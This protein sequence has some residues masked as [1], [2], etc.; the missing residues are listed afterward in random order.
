MKTSEKLKPLEK[1]AL[2]AVALRWGLGGFALTAATLAGIQLQAQ[3][4]AAHNSR[5]PVN[6][7]AGRIELQDRQNRVSLSGNVIV[8]QAGLT[9]NSQ[10]ML[11]NY[12]DGGSLDI[13]RITATGGVSVSRGSE[14]A[15]GDVAIYDLN[16]QIITMAGNVRLQRGS[17]NLSGGRLVIDLKTGVSSIDGR[18]SGSA[19]TSNPE[20][21][22]VTRSNGRVRGTFSVPQN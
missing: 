7:D 13:S 22:S 5:A 15:L 20:E 10:R 4:I 16:R 14:S 18:S 3:S 1:P 19:S 11:V 12:S 6:F 21:G 2:L 9:V 8:T 17:D